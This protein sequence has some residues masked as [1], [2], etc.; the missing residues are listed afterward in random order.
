[1]FKL[2]KI[3]HFNDLSSLVK[4]NKLKKK[5]VFLIYRMKDLMQKNYE[6]QMTLISIDSLIV[7]IFEAR[8]LNVPRTI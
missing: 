5:N 2:K 1:M 4:K 3:E 7:L 8:N 6:F